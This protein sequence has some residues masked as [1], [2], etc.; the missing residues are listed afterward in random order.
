MYI[1]NRE[2]SILSFNSYCAE[3]CQYGRS[4]GLHCGGNN[5][6]DEPCFSGQIQAVRATEMRFYSFQYVIKTN[7]SFGCC[8]RGA[9]EQ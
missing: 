5:L 2:A 8:D 4:L 9:V 3:Q 7:S 1:L 6:I